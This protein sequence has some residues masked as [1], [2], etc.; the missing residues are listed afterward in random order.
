[1]ESGK[2]RLQNHSN[3][4]FDLHGVEPLVPKSW[5]IVGQRELC[6][7]VFHQCTVMELAF[8]S[9]TKRVIIARSSILGLWIPANPRTHT[10]NCWTF[11]FWTIVIWTSTFAGDSVVSHQ[12]DDSRNDSSLVMLKWSAR[13]Q[14]NMK[15]PKASY[16]DNAARVCTVHWLPALRTAVCPRTA[17]EGRRLICLTPTVY[18]GAFICCVDDLFVDLLVTAITAD[19]LSTLPS[20]STAGGLTTRGAT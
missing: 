20:Q 16:L 7:C 3:E 14:Q 10:E 17:A 15:S 19:T 8:F 5:M 11:W 2:R 18:P 6:I 1:M 9:I 12:S 4:P 13:R